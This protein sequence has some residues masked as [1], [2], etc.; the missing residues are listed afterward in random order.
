MLPE[1]VKFLERLGV[2]RRALAYLTIQVL[3]KT[4]YMWKAYMDSTA[5]RTARTADVG[6]DGGGQILTPTQVNGRERR[7][8]TG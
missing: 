8:A 6:K 7:A 5:G 3:N 2:P 1:T 4:W